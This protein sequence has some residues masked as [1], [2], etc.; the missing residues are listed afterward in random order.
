MGFFLTNFL[1]TL[2]VYGLTSF[3]YP[4]G[5]VIPRICLLWAAPVI[6]TLVASL[7]TRK[8]RLGHALVAE[9]LAIYAMSGFY[10]LV[11]QQKAIVETMKW[12]TSAYFL[13]G[14]ILA[15]LAGLLA[16]WILR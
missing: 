6:G 12:V 3:F 8:S 7:V 9:A 5:A 15:L 16:K 4:N 11:Y 14:A 10:C 1:V 2:T 13:P